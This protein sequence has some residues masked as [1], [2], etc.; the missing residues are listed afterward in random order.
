MASF[1]CLI[2]LYLWKVSSCLCSV[3]NS[4]VWGI[5]AGISLLVEDDGE[6]ERI[7]LPYVSSSGGKYILEPLLTFLNSLA[8][9]YVTE[10]ESSSL[11]L[12]SV[13]YLGRGV[14]EVALEST[15]S[16]AS[17]NVF[18]TQMCWFMYFSISGL[19]VDT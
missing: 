16:L 4:S 14:F 3:D 2:Y 17:C 15:Y 7:I 13:F 8:K 1:L 9:T 5:V 18:S 11:N 19:G 10:G 6:S 12:F